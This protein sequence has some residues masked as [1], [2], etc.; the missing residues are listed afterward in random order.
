MSLQY[1]SHFYQ[2]HMKK[3]M[4]QFLRYFL[5]TGIH[6]AVFSLCQSLPLKH[7]TLKSQNICNQI[8]KIPI[9]INSKV[10]YTDLHLPKSF[11]MIHHLKYQQI[12][13]LNS[14]NQSNEFQ[15]TQGTSF[16]DAV[17]Q[18]SQLKNPPAYISRQLVTSICKCNNQQWQ[19][20][21]TY[22]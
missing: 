5:F 10:H 2:C 19:S 22:K 8:N 11:L 7:T 14:T 13:I 20:Y 3:T 21:H 18:D 1:A 17:S 16:I 6:G 15:S 12:I 4:L 9:F